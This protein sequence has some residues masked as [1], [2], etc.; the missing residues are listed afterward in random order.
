MSPQF[1]VILILFFF[2]EIHVLT[3]SCLLPLLNFVFFCLPSKCSDHFLFFLLITVLFVSFSEHIFFF[4]FLKFSLPAIPHN[5][6]YNRICRP[7][8]AFLTFTVRVRNNFLPST[9]D[10]FRCAVRRIVS[11]F[12][13]SSEKVALRYISAHSAPARY[14]EGRS[15]GTGGSTL[16]LSKASSLMTLGDGDV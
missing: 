7:S 10:F 4:P 16:G 11:Y 3:I 5:F 15:P 13:A 12:F 8:F 6:I 1:I 2:F 14:N 9:S